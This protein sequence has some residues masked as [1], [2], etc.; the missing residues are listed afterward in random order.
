MAVTIDRG[1]RRALHPLH[2]V[3][4]ASTIPLFL[5]TAL[6]DWAYA[7]SYEV[8]WT[9]FASWLILGGLVFGGWALLWALIEWFRDGARLRSRSTIYFIVLLAMWGGGFTD[10]LIHGKD[11]WASMP[12]GLIL[13]V[14]VALLAIAATWIGHSNLRAEV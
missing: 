10:A 8:Q 1:R 9:N 13:S 3:L 12:E 4:L 2:A 5:G 7:S 11:A 14:F 6:S